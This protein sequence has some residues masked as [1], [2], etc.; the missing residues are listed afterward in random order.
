[1][2]AIRLMTGILFIVLTVVS[3]NAAETAVLAGGCFWGVEGIYEHVTG[4]EKVES[5][6]SGGDART[7][8]YNAVSSGFSKHAESVRIQFDPEQISYSQILDIFFTVAHDPTQLNYQGPDHGRQYRSVVFYLDDQQR[9]TAEA[10]IR[11][12]EANRVYADKIVT[13]LQP[14]DK[15]Y[16]A[17]MYHQD[18]MQRNPA[19]PYV[20]YWD[21]PKIE[22]LKEAFPALYRERSWTVH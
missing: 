17:E 2:K 18:F 20:S 15:F 9:S 5:G 3:L 16:T 7:A 19:H 21:W 12:L 10:V 22:H 4:V 6:Y 13:I 1:M 14:F 11:Q 8:N